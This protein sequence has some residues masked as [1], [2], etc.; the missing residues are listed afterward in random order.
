MSLRI[1]PLKLG[2]LFS[3]NIALALLHPETS[4]LFSA[5]ILNGYVPNRFMKTAIIPI[6]RNETE[7]T[8]IENSYKPIVH[9]TAA[10]KIFEFCLSIILEEY[11][12]THGQ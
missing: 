3:T 4:L 11:L 6:I 8:I 9:V 12:V 10:S 5:F 2:M 7:Y 1:K